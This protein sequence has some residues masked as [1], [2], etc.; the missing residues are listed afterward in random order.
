[1]SYNNFAIAYEPHNPLYPAADK[2]ADDASLVR[3]I[4]SGDA[5]AEHTLAEKFYRQIKQIGRQLGADVTLCDDL[6]QEALLKV[7]QNLRGSRLKD[8]NKLQAYIAQTARFTY[9]GWQRNKNNQLELRESCDDAKHSNDVEQEFLMASN[10]LWVIQQIEK[11]TMWR[12]RQLLLRFYINHQ[13]KSD[14]CAALDL[15]HD[16]FDKLICRARKR[17]KKVIQS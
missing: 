12:D 16:Q 4:G 3:R 10:R 2:M 17:L 5:R 14:I 7:I 6:A 9:Y 8:A 13:E 15:K 11:L 1:M